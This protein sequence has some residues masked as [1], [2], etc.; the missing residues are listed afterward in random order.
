MGHEN[1]LGAQQTDAFGAL[2][3][4]AGDAGAFADVG[5]HF[6]GVTVGGQR[7]LMPLLGGGLQALF[8]G[9]ALYGGALQRGGI[10]VYMQ[11]T[12]LAIDQQRRTRR[13]Q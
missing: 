12:A 10:S 8:A 3:H 9:V 6:D 1:K 4:R 5:E 2:L 7:R 13:Q 11:A